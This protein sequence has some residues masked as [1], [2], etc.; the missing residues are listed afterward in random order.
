MRP[1]HFFLFL[2][3]LTGLVT[4]GPRNLYDAGSGPQVVILIPPAKPLSALPSPPTEAPSVPQAAP[5]PLFSQEG[6]ASWY[7][8]TRR[9]ITANGEHFLGNA[10]TAAHRSLPFNTMV[11][12]TDLKSG[13]TGTLRIND[14][15][16]F[17]R[18]RIIDLSTASAARIGMAKGRMRKVRIEVFAED[19]SGPVTI[20]PVAEKA[21]IHLRHAGTGPHG[22]VAAVHPR[23]GKLALR[24]DRKQ[25]SHQTAA[26]DMKSARAPLSH[27]RL[28]RHIGVNR[29]A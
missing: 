26:K 3:L 13:R 5:H 20:A 24:S 29:R 23:T 17:V 21:P 1:V 6:L 11:R 4:C 8:S 15:G 14:R 28:V 2:P 12:V 16:P 19:Q 25:K 10:L 27:R 9:A 7:R 22:T 18:G